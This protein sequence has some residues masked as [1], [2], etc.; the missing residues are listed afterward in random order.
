[1][2]QH[3][4]GERNLAETATIFALAYRA[5]LANLEGKTKFFVQPSDLETDLAEG[6]DLKIRRNG[7]FL[8]VDVTDSRRQKP[9]KILRTVEFAKSGG[10]WVYV[11]KVDWTEA[12]TVVI[13]P[14]F[15]RAYD[16]LIHK[17]DGQFIAIN[18][19]CPTHGNNCALA[20]KLWDFAERINNT[21]ASS[22]TQAHDFAIPVSKPPF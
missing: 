20:R 16:Q 7:F 10:R 12:S 2:A 18:Q 6:T 4:W 14:C 5:G 19:A 3:G 9:A 11:L 8:R 13:D 1:M 15:T 17:R 21:L 22:K